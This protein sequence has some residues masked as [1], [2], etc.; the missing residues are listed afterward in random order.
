MREDN[1][2]KT[3]VEAQFR[4]QIPIEVARVA[5]IAAMA[6]RILSAC[7]TTHELL[8]AVQGLFDHMSAWHDGL[9]PIAK[10]SEL[11]QMPWDESKV[12]LAYV[13]LG[14]LGAV[15]LIFRR[16]LSMYKNRSKDQKHSLHPAERGRLAAIFNDG[17]V[18]A[19]QASQILY[20][21]LGEQAGIRHCWTVM[22]DLT[23]SHVAYPASYTAKT[24]SAAT[25]P[26]SPRQSSSTL[27]ARCK[28][29]T[30]PKPNGGN[31]SA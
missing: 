15:T 6:M 23:S 3:S 9:P 4:S 7:S 31:T 2:A 5:V 20:L 26:S 27:R 22:Y 1:A 29:T 30:H 24:I 18:A 12:T 16:T 21:L 17:I 25:P 28:S 10:A 8:P 19:K 11:S 14:H 13:H